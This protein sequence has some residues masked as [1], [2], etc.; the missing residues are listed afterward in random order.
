MSKAPTYVE[1]SQ[2]GAP[3]GSFTLREAAAKAGMHP[4]DLKRALMRE[5]GVY[6]CGRLVFV[7]D[8]ED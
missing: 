1:V 4:N 2:D 7:A 8:A 3:L 6:T 5:Q